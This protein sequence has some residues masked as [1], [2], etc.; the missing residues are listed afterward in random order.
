M[1]KPFL[2]KCLNCNWTRSSLGTK[3]DL[4]D[5][6]EIKSNCSTCGKSRKFVCPQ[7]KASVVMRRVRGNT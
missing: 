7:C 5:L 1:Q 3:E 4:V 6:K 2:L